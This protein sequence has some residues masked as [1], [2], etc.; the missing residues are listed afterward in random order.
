MSDTV[1]FV[2]SLPHQLVASFKATLEEAVNADLL[3]H[4]VDVSSPEALEQIES[5]NK[6]LAELGCGEKPILEV[7]NKVDIVKKIGK[8]EM[9]Q[10]LFPDAVVISAKTGLGLDG[11][12]E[13]VAAKYKGAELLL[14]VACTQ[15]NGKLQSFL[16]AYG[17]IIKEQY[18]DG[19][20]LIDARLGQN[21]LAPLKR[22]QPE[23]IEIVQS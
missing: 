5:V 12:N 4:M 6:V 7:F 23:T 19:T 13:A 14:R 10:T 20:V 1:G 15:S 22:L 21:Q 2:K 16:R 18:H 9:L 17:T 8:L 11:L 3:L